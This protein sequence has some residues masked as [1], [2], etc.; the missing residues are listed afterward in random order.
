MQKPCGETR[1]SAHDDLKK[2]LLAKQFK[3]KRLPLEMSKSW[4]RQL[5]SMLH[6]RYDISTLASKLYRVS[7]SNAR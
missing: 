2:R 1:S 7:S 5:A 6:A 4:N 3:S